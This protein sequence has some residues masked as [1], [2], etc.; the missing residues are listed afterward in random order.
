M[1]R[2]AFITK[3]KFPVVRGVAA[4]AVLLVLC[5]SASSARA[6]SIQYTV[7]SGADS[8]SIVFTAENGYLLAA[9]TNTSTSGVTQGMM[10][11]G[12]SFNVDGTILNPTAFQEIS[13][14]SI[15]GLTKT[16]GAYS[17]GGTAFDYTSNITANTHWGDFS[18]SSKVVSL[19]A[20]TGGQPNG[21]IIP[22][23]GT[24]V[25]SFNSDFDPDLIGTIDFKLT[26]A[27]LS[28]T[29]AISGDISNVNISFGTNPDATLTASVPSPTPEP[30]TLTLMGLGLAG[31][32]LVSRRRLI[33]A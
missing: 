29:T 4:L 6:D 13:G 9:V 10:V 3:S 2:K 27:S 18:N 7:N 15:S 14:A 32:I 24:T 16:T 5:Y 23:S 21:M 28:T 26:D 20:L 31:L 11:S 30:G 8:A 25:N 33:Q 17:G 22:N 12:F 1:L 19:T